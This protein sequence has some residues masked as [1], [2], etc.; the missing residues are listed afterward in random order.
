MPVLKTGSRLG[1]YT[2]LDLLR[3]G[4]MAC[5]YLAQYDPPDGGTPA[6]VAVKLANTAADVPRDRSK[7][8][9]ELEAFY[10][11]A[12]S[13][14]VEVL[15]KLHHPNIVRLQPIPWGIKRDPYIARAT[16]VTGAPWFCAM[17][18]LPGGSVAQLTE[19]H[20][21]LEPKLAVEVA[22][23]LA[24]ALD[25]MHAKGYAHLDVKPDNILL[26][27]SLGDEG[28]GPPHGP[29]AEACPQAVLIDFGIARRHHETGLE[30]GSLPYMPPEMIPL[31]NGARAPELGVSSPP[32]DVY[33]VGV[34]LYQL[35]TGHLPFSGRSDTHVTTAILRSDPT[36]PSVYNH[37]LPTNLEELVLQIMQKD[38]ERRP[39]A[40][41]LVLLLDGAVSPRVFAAAAPPTGATPAAG[42]VNRPQRRN[43]ERLRLRLYAGAAI[44]FAVLS[45]GQLLWPLRPPTGTSPGSTVVAPT[46]T[47]TPLPALDLGVTATAA[48]VLAPATGEPVNTPTAEVPATANPTPDTTRVA[49]ANGDVPTPPVYA[50]ATPVNTRTPTPLPPPT[51]APQATP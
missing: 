28:G 47:M 1:P 26:R 4:G 42:V 44:L 19:A 34:L 11:E 23:Q 49:P 43:H 27:Q 6:R 32:V 12:L 13:N 5:I 35:L 45:L 39:T 51:V 8:A 41:E 37:E 10:Y 38:P 33:A 36:R 40:Q 31:V 48:P 29:Q 14:E 50:T 22:Y 15:K 16:N 20:K 2:V 9:Q 7:S 21:P 3:V 18:Y 25:Y 46:A 17:D 30:A 24:L